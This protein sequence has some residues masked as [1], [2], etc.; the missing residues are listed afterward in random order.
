VANYKLNSSVAAG[1]IL[2]GALSLGALQATAAG[3]AP[4]HDTQW[5]ARFG[6]HVD[7]CF[8][9]AI[10]AACGVRRPRR[11]DS[12]RSNALEKKNSDLV[13]LGNKPTDPKATVKDL[14]ADCKWRPRRELQLQCSVDRSGHDCDARSRRASQFLYHLPSN[15]HV[16]A[17][18]AEAMPTDLRSAATGH[19]CHRGF[20]KTTIPRL[21]LWASAGLTSFGYSAGRHAAAA[22]TNNTY[23]IVQGKDTVAIVLEMVH[24]VRIIRLK[25]ASPHRWPASL[26]RRFRGAATM[27]DSLVVET[28][29]ISQRPKPSWDH[30]K[31]QSDGAIHARERRP[32]AL[33]V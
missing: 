16:S 12:D 7:K 26:V 28:T 18:T 9:D 11:P 19:R 23:Q 5:P 4:P 2:T 20:G 3:Y 27:A 8:A 21:G 32:G 1:W 17:F 10:R 30:G 15:G 25:W 31:P 29:Q 24:D 33:S 6:R 14:P 22:I 13:A